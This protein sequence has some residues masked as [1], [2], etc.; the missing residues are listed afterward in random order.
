MN[1]ENNPADQSIDQVCSWIGWTRLTQQ[2]LG[3]NPS[4]CKD[5]YG[6]AVRDL[7]KDFD[8]RAALFDSRLGRLINC[9]SVRVDDH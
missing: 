7:A 9:S 2:A 8:D 1:D 3:H 5:R 4:G 6:T